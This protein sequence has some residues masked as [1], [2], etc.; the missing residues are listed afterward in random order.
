MKILPC[1]V[2]NFKGGDSLPFFL[3]FREGCGLAKKTSQ[4]GLI[5]QAKLNTQKTQVMSSLKADVTTIQGYLDADKTSK[6]KL[7]LT[8][9]INIS[10]TK[11]Q[12]NEQL[13]TL[14]NLPT[15]KLA[16]VIDT[17]G[18]TSQVRKAL[19]AV[20]VQGT[21]QKY[22]PKEITQEYTNLISLLK[23]AGQL[24]QQNILNQS[25]GVVDTNFASKLQVIQAQIDATRAKI[26]KLKVA[27]E[28]Y[29]VQEA[30]VSA[31]ILTNAQKIDAANQKLLE[32]QEKKAKTDSTPSQE[33]I[34][35]YR[36]LVT[37]IKEFGQLQKQ[38]IFADSDKDQKAYGIR[39]EEYQKKITKLREEIKNLQ[40]A[41]VD[42]ST[43]EHQVAEQT[44]KSSE[45]IN[46][47][48]EKE[49][50]ARKRK[51]TQLKL[52]K[53]AI[54]ALLQSQHKLARSE[55]GYEMSGLSSGIASTIQQSG[56]SSKELD[57]KL[58]TYTGA[59]RTLQA[60]ARNAGVVSQSAFQKI[61][62][63]A[64][65]FMSWMGMTTS[66]AALIRQLKQVVTTV[67]EIDNA[68]GE[69]RVVTN[70]SKREIQEFTQQATEGAKRVG[71][72]VTELINSA[73][74]FARLG[75]GTSDSGSLAE[76]T[77]MFS[78]AGA[79]D[80]SDA[81][82]AIT[83][84]VKAYGYG[85]DELQLVLDKIF[86]VDAAYAISSQDIGEGLRNAG[87]ALATAGNSIEQ[88]MA[89]LVAANNSIQDIDKASTALRTITAR[90]RSSSTELDE[91]GETMEEEY[92]TVV[93]YRAKLKAITGV[94][95]LEADNKSF[96]DT[97]QILKEISNVFDSL[98]DK[99]QASVIEMIAGTRNQN[100]FASIMKSMGEADQVLETTANA[101]G[102]LN[103]ANEI[104]LDTVEG[105]TQQFK[106]TYQEF[107]QSVMDSDLIKGT[108]DIGSG[109]LG[110]LTKANDL[111]G[112][113][114]V[115]AGALG[116]AL[117]A[118]KDIGFVKGNSDDK[119]D[120]FGQWTFEDGKFS[121]IDK[122]GAYT[123]LINDYNKAVQESIDPTKQSGDAVAK[124][125]DN[126]D[127]G[128]ETF[129]Q[130]LKSLNGA[131]ASA[132]GYTAYLKQMNVTQLK[133]RLSAIALNFAISAGIG[134]LVTGAVKLGQYIASVIPTY[135]N[136]SKWAAE[137][138]EEA[139][140]VQQEVNS[141][142]Q[143]IETNNETIK[144]RQNLINSGKGSLV[145]QD[146]ISKLQEENKLLL[147]Q[148][149]TQ[150]ELLAEKKAN[151]QKT[152]SDKWNSYNSKYRTDYSSALK[153]SEV[154]KG[155]QYST[156]TRSVD[157]QKE[158]LEGNPWYINAEDATQAIQNTIK[159]YQELIQVRSK[160]L[161]KDNLSEDETKQVET[162][163][164]NIDFLR[165]K[166]QDY[167]NDFTN[168]EFTD[169]TGK[170]YSQVQD[171]VTL[172]QDGLHPEE[173]QE[174]IKN[175]LGT[176]GL[177]QINEELQKLATNGQLTGEAL[178]NA[179]FASFINKCKDLGII[180]D[181]DNV[182]LTLLANTLL[183]LYDVTESAVQP[184]VALND[185]LTDIN[186][187]IDS[188]Q[189]AFST[190]S[191]A[192]EEY[193]TNGW[194][195]VDTLQSLMS[196]DEQYLDTLLNTAD[197]LSL[198]TD[199]YAAL[200]N[201][202][203]DNMELQVLQNAYSQMQKVSNEAEAQSYL[204][205]AAAMAT[206]SEQARILL[207]DMAA[208]YQAAS[209][210][211][212]V[213][214]EAID[215]IIGRTQKYLNLIEKARSGIG[216]QSVTKSTSGLESQKKALN[217]LKQS[218][219]DQLNTAKQGASDIESLISYVIKMISQG[220]EDTIKGLETT[221][222]QMETAYKKEQENIKQ[223]SEEL[224]E[225]YDKQT[226]ALKEQK[227]VIDDL[228][229]Q[230]LE[231]LDLK[232]AEDD[233]N[234]SLTEKQTE[235]ARL[236]AEQNALAMDTSDAGGKR[237]LELQDEINKKQQEIY[238]LQHDRDITLQKDA[239][240]AEKDRIQ[241]AYDEQTEKLKKEYDAQKEAL[242][243]R[244]DLL[245][246][247]YEAK[248]ESLDKQISDIRDY[249]SNETNLRKEAIDLINA[250]S[251]HLYA[252]LIAWN[253]KYG[254]MIDAD[255][256][257][258]WDSAYDALGRYTRYGQYDCIYAL[259][260]IAAKQVELQDKIDAIDAKLVPLNEQ[261]SSAK[262]H[263]SNMA[264]SFSSG[265]SSMSK[266]LTDAKDL[267]N[268]LSSMSNLSTIKM[269]EA[270]S[271]FPSEY[272]K[273]FA[274]SIAK[275][276]SYAAAQQEKFSANK[277]KRGY[278]SGTRFVPRTGYHFTQE[279]G[280]ELIVRNQGR[281]TYL[282]RG[283]GVIKSRLTDI[284]LNFA[285]N[286]AAFIASHSQNNTANNMAQRAANLVNAPT[287]ATIRM[288]DIIIQG[289][290]DQTAL[291]KIRAMQENAAKQV[292]EKMEQLQRRRGGMQLANELI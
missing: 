161:Q 153:P 273:E 271:K 117:S 23:Q 103:R 228:I 94:D 146:E 166:L 132:E 242:D 148:L 71:S 36:E 280:E 87:S 157:A 138:V 65:K 181:T 139:K 150:R 5:I 190:L 124:F 154:Q 99:D 240:N 123:D 199:Q 149:E 265:V 182:S 198:N 19:E 22:S 281:Y 60:E 246:Q 40:V 105:K 245:E 204:D 217:D 186:N 49:A 136:V 27:D 119:L 222:D 83:A 89:L 30:K 44:R 275:S 191:N 133:V 163:G 256:K 1:W 290:A 288:G 197:G 135:E 69:L 243:K 208:L 56:L 9:K 262:T 32:S 112:P 29:G 205:K 130:Y 12:I 238:E 257:Q 26:E 53:A 274:A 189:G 54:D 102:S 104:Y 52:L 59:F 121:A 172:I 244:L 79:I 110:F 2:A 180:T 88:S 232:E 41:G 252:D 236:E 225:A 58:Q 120:F 33:I 34:A 51:T 160:L 175:L 287:S 226:E 91:L 263:A 46:E 283:D 126:I 282:E 25:K 212:G 292:F 145:D 39:V 31:Q 259:N 4:Y 233:Y 210:M 272:G 84:I 16:S 234:K 47:A 101:A 231:L 17:S 127:D 200:M 258:A 6:T 187:Q 159:L 162:L 82:S 63:A 147:I 218:Y 116:A 93:K 90:I 227:K 10:E 114:T 118:F 55:Q 7:L 167:Q 76:I 156:T 129:K 18:L 285:S 260:Q 144:E 193:N 195:S 235:L 14:K 239:L 176:D 24:Q 219:Q 237:K 211:G 209:A 152:L 50:A 28:D 97:Y 224:S 251:S 194:I 171:L 241:E 66:V 196:L 266:M 21:V 168:G 13:S 37:T 170:L 43:Q 289:S 158:A 254:S 80:V 261:L 155:S 291:N 207:E 98:S 165:Q 86:A 113:L 48:T 249:V 151:E 277:Y 284:L 61:G 276:L 11:K 100:V 229:D 64:T 96:K 185:S 201:A 67:S 122:A 140:T 213:Q 45:A 268:T 128:N 188:L 73:V 215:Q 85:A 279:N 3:D 141:I 70:A 15:I 178:Q 221:L 35:K 247:E 108:I 174:Q 269:L 169:S 81:T 220:Y 164:K 38:N 57:D 206:T 184:M 143:Q 8:G 177:N 203:L 109:L 223:Q 270:F 202:K 62:A 77:T 95:I 111:V 278:A 42:Y 183:R 192:V 142:A 248:K 230:Q 74:T 131:S 125:L 214:L 106:A 137:A 264:F 253:T 267:K 78:K 92:N 75:Y 286:P 179:K 68:L 250:K 173:V 216:K 115:S 72:S 134:L 20:G 107:A 255:I